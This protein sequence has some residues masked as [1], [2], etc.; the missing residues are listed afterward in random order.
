MVMAGLSLASMRAT[1]WAAWGA[2]SLV[3]CLI[4]N[5]FGDSLDGTV[6]RVR[7]QQRP[8]YGYYV[9]HVIDLVG[10]TALMAGLS[11]SGLMSPLMAA[12]VATVYLLVCAEAYLS[13]HAAGVFKMSFLGFGP[14]ELRIVLAIGVL[15]ALA[16]PEIRVPVLGP[17]LLFDI[18]GA[19]A[20][21]GLTTAFVT[22]VYR[23]TWALYAAEPLP[24]R[25][26][27]SR[28]A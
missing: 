6:A 16:T 4:A 24:A 7:G 20:I 21:V 22:S 15:K 28:A 27:S 9:D 19:G 23:T 26:A 14:T 10:T 25:T 12:A 11:F 17:M 18:G 8:R 3:I 1:P 13:T 2:V 5:W